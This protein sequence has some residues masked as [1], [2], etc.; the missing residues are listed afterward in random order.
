MA[1]KFFTAMQVGHFH[2]KEHVM[3]ANSLPHMTIHCVVINSGIPG[4]G[5]A[6][7]VRSV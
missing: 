5:A 2:L 3:L 1:P 7:L 4:H 6:S